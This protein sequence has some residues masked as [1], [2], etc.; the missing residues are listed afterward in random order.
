MKHIYP[1]NNDSKR[2]VISVRAGGKP[3]AGRITNFVLILFWA[4]YVIYL[5]KGLRPAADP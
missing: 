4:N 5:F 2:L 1:E 3:P